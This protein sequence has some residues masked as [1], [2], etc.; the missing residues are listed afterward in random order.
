MQSYRNLHTAASAISPTLNQVNNEVISVQECAQT[1]GSIID[2]RII[3]TSTNGQ[4]G[5][6]N[7]RLVV[8][9][10]YLSQILNDERILSLLYEKLKTLNFISQGDSGGPLNKNGKTYGI[11]SFV[12]SAGC[13][14]GY[15]DA[16]TRVVKFLSWI[17]SKT[18]VTPQ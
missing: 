10:Q 3:C 8:V 2:E 17:E 6:C 11:A 12:A 14:S 1:Y 5:T 9:F 4:K 13:E 15:P 7:V 18:G 16:F